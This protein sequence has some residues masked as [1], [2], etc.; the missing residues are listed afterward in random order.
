MPLGPKNA[1]FRL[2][3]FDLLKGIGVIIF[4]LS[5]SYQRYGILQNVPVVVALIGEGAR[6][7]FY[8]I[9]GLTFK[10]K[11][12]SKMLK[13]TF[14]SLMIPYFWVMLAYGLLFPLVRYPFMPD[15]R[16]VFTYGLRYVCAF[17]LGNI[18]YGK[19]IFGFEIFWCTPMYFFLSMFIALNILN[20][21]LKIKSVR[22]QALCA[23]ACV[24]IGTILLSQKMFLFSLCYGLPA[25]GFCYV[26]YIIKKYNLFLRLRGNL[27]FYC[28]AAVSFLAVWL[29]N[30]FTEPGFLLDMAT[31]FGTTF[32]A[33]ILLFGNYCITEMNLGGP[34]WLK[35]MGLYSYWIICIHSFETEAI[36][37]FLY[38]QALSS[39]NWW[40]VFGLELVLKA[41][42]L[43]AGCV[44]LKAITKW[45]YK[46]KLQRVK[47]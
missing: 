46:R 41:I 4:I 38:V 36:P 42:I 6:T 28:A 23:S 15:W 18:E 34:G 9:S 39:Y 37:W 43:T 14:Q 5:H 12:P 2:G 33:M 25:V 8:V 16:E 19:V 31:W 45:C 44:A 17:L 3:S 30:V 24:L 7:A 10:E 27:W 11:S 22:L 1:K 20:L 32:A 29:A 47:A 40:L 13:K 21:I 26:G 35:K